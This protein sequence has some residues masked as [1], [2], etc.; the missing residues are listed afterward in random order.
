VVLEAG[1]ALKPRGGKER[2]FERMDRGL[3][4]IAFLT[5]LKLT[6]LDLGPRGTILGGFR[7]TFSR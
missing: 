4:G 5:G 6:T 2:P 1:D 7:F 3:P